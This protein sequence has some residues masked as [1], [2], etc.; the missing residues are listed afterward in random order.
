ML[1]VTKQLHHSMGNRRQAREAGLKILF[2]IEYTGQHLREIFDFYVK[3]HQLGEEVVGFLKLLLEGALRN[4]QEIDHF[5][6]ASSTN[7][8]LSRM[9]AVDRNMLRLATF[10]LIYCHDIPSSVTINE[11]VEIV[12]KY[13]T[14]ESA[15]F[16]NGVLDKIAKDRGEA[17]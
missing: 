17:P 14:E 10:E 4:I 9:A 13:G 16:V 7:W 3:E 5:I 15:S 1:L 2:Q 11:A 6:E 8:K 12:K